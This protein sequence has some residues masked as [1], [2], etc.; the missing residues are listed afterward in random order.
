[1]IPSSAS[2]LSSSAS[3]FFCSPFCLSD[4]R[5]KNFSNEPKKRPLQKKKKTIFWKKN[6]FSMPRNH[7]KQLVARDL[8]KFWNKSRRKE[9]T[10]PRQKWN[11]KAFQFFMKPCPRKNHAK[12]TNEREKWVCNPWL[13]KRSNVVAKA[14]ARAKDR[15]KPKLKFLLQTTCAGNE[16]KSAT[17][18]RRWFRTLLVQNPHIWNKKNFRKKQWEWKKLA[19][20]PF[21]ERRN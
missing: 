17:G 10:Y 15:K 5:Y 14:W 11:G 19:K 6:V 2:R 3:S 4:W 21:S 16:A 7:P 8:R 12:I 20:I 9:K 18:H 13:Q 1:M